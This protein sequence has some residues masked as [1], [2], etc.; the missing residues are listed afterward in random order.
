MIYSMCLQASVIL[1]KTKTSNIH[2]NFTHVN[3]GVY[4]NK[5]T[6]E[7]TRTYN[8]TYVCKAILDI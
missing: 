1:I 7:N 8:R 6:Q 4:S 3:T 2:K 5:D